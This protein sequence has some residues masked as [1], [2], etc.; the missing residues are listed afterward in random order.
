MRLCRFDDDRVGV[1]HGDATLHPLATRPV[2]FFTP[3]QQ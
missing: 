3:F 1:V 2:K